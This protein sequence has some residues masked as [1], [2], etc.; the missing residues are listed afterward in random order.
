VRALAFG[1]AILGLCV[2]AWGLRYKLSLYDP[3]GAG[4]RHM[5]AAKLLTGKERRD[6]PIVNSHPVA[7]SSTLAFLAGLL[8]VTFAV[9]VI[10]SRPGSFSSLRLS[11]TRT[12]VP[13]RTPRAGIF[14]RPPPRAH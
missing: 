6:L 3:P 14:I 5:P 13:A 7:G 11:A 12:T 10:D 8:L 9:W 2:F 1:L 4:S